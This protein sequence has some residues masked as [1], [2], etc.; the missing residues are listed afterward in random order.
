MSTIR[1]LFSINA[2]VAGALVLGVINNIAIAGL[3]G[4]DRRIDSYF[5]SLM[6]VRL[7]MEL[8]VDYLGKNFLPA[9]ARRHAES[10]ASASVL[11]SL[12]VTQMALA[13]ALVSILLIMI[14]PGIF[15]LILPGFKA[16][17]IELVASTFVIMAPSLVF[18]VIETFHQYIWQ[19]DEHYSRVMLARTLV[20]LTLTVFI[21]GFSRW[22]DVLALP[23]GFLCGH[24]LCAAALSVGV[25]YKYR[26]MM[27]FS[28]SDVRQILG[29]STVL[30]GT[31]V[32][33]RSRSVIVQYFGSQLGD[34]AISAMAIAN[35]ICHPIY[36]KA[37][38]G[39]RMIVFSRSAKAS[40]KQDISAFARL[41]RLSINGILLIVTPVA[42]WY[43]IEADIIIRAVF[44]R[45]EFT[46]AMASLVVA[47][48]IGYA[49][50]VI[51]SGVVQILSNGFYAMNRISVPAIIMPIGTAVF[52]VLAI[53]LS[54]GLGVLGLTVS[55]SITAALVAVALMVIFRRHVKKFAVT[56]ISLN[57]VKYTILSVIAVLVGRELRVISGYDGIPG[58]LISGFSVMALYLLLQ[59]L[60]RDKML[61]LII[62]KT[63]LATKNPIRSGNP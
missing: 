46:D 6:L 37:Q 61:K 13:A 20:P 51:F 23:I 22:L 42:V 63:V 11:A 18:M 55:A 38:V 14:A 1:K 45:G 26:F 17:D 8:I 28:D 15:S 57:I 53:F 27:S 34:G 43:A 54:P 24:I 44:Q 19:H 49:G 31:G 41:Y 39:I 10:E 21:V 30:M 36:Q 52:L 58:F 3:F 7:F 5:A 48:L 60:V 50:S 62:R 59:F 32:F 16:A 47:A 2:I 40:A 25:P 29:N 9:F 12:V 4:L 56:E 35:K 33:A